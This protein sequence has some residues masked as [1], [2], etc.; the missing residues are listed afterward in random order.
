MTG[1]AFS[2]LEIRLIENW[3]AE[4]LEDLEWLEA[5]VLAAQ[6]NRTRDLIAVMIAQRTRR[7]HEL[8][9]LNRQ[10]TIGG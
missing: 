6:N 4:I 3:I 2:N 9:A 5:A 7:L 10:R 1:R 8:R